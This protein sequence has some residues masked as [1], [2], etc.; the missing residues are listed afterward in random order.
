M[1]KI[2]YLVAAST[3][4]LVLA[5]PIIFNYSTNKVY[6]ELAT[7]RTKYITANP[8][9]DLDQKLIDNIQLFVNTNSRCALSISKDHC[10]P[11]EAQKH[12]IKII[13]KENE[14]I[15]IL[16][17]KITEDHQKKHLSLF[18]AGL[19]LY[20]NLPYPTL[21]IYQNGELQK[22]ILGYN[23]S[24]SKIFQLLYPHSLENLLIK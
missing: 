24:D 5:V 9:T 11:C 1:K 7:Q 19:S 10:P 18:Y 22:Q 23:S 8:F 20:P 2:V 16:E 15:P 12:A 13:A 21:I 6:N 4:S 3:L 17:L 14:L